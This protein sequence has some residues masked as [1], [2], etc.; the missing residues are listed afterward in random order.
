MFF[1]LLVCLSLA[2]RRTISILLETAFSHI[3]HRLLFSDSY[4]IRS[5]HRICFRPTTYSSPVQVVYKGSYCISSITLSILTCQVEP[6]Y[7]MSVYSYVR[8]TSRNI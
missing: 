7:H 1:S 6:A 2:Q 8:Y 5:S 4:E 3:N